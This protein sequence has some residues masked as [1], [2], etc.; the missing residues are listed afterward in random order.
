MGMCIYICITI[1]IYYMIFFLKWDEDTVSNDA[2]I[3]GIVSMLGGTNRISLDFAYLGSGQNKIY[4][5]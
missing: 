2:T 1:A 5:G 4:Q 3:G